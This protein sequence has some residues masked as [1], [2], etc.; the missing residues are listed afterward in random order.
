MGFD[1]ECNL[2]VE[3]HDDATRRMI[4]AVRNRLLAEHLGTT[5]ERVAECTPEHASLIAGIDSLRGNTRSLEPLDGEVDKAVESLLPDQKLVDPERPVS[6]GEMADL[7]MHPEERKSTLRQ[8][9]PALFTLAALAALAAVWRWTPL[10]QW[11]DTESLQQLLMQISASPLALLAV[12]ASYVAA[13]LLSIP[14]TLLVIVT[15]LVFGP[16]TGFLYALGGAL[17]SGLCNFVLGR[18]LASDWVRR[19]A[20]S[21]LNRL[22]EKLGKRGILAIV[23]LRLVPIAPYGVVNLVAGATHVRLRDFLLG[24]AIGLAPGLLAIT[25]FSHQVA[26]TIRRPELGAFAL[27][28]GVTGAL[29]AGGWVL[30]RWV[31]RREANEPPATQSK[32]SS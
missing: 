1:T 20:G 30:Y 29:A 18:W 25:V 5:P 10:N 14:L 32:R 15:A 3:A 11:L 24:S 22:S 19:L 12:P 31:S 17:L 23:A 16:W 26:A 27:L 21:R 2:V 6:A 28:A 7:M 13:G 8:L 9:A 4:R